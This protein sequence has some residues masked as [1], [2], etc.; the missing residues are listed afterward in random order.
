MAKTYCLVRDIEHPFDLIGR[1]T[2]LRLNHHVTARS[3]FHN[4]R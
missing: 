1:Y 4:G 3:H 2:F